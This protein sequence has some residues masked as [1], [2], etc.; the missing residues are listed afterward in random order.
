MSEASPINYPANTR[1]AKVAKDPVEDKVEPAEKKKIE[2]VVSG[3]VIQRKKPLSKKIAETF[4]GDDAKSVGEYILFDVCIPAAKAMIADATSQGA[5]RLLFGE[6]RSS[7]RTANTSYRPGYTSYDKVRTPGPRAFETERSSR[8][9]LSRRARASHD[10]SEI[11]LADRGEAEMVLDNMGNILDSYGLVT[12][13]DLYD[14]V[15]ITGNFTDDKWGW[16]DLR[17]AQVQRVREG[18]LLDLPKPEPID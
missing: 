12:V 2:P 8:P 11:V 18:Y 7:R 3:K 4:T 6:V 10:F 5:E 9:D 16:T 1:K 13:S 15:E 14:L 17:S